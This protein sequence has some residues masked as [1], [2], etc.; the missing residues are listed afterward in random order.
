MAVYVR[1]RG[2][3]FE[4]RVKHR[5]LPRAFYATFEVEAEAWS[6]GQ[7]LDALLARGVVP[8][9]LATRDAPRGADPLLIEVIRGYTKAAPITES[10]DALLGTMLAELDGVR[11]SRV[12][13]AWC[14]EYVRQLKMRRNLAPSSI[15]KRVGVLARVVD[16]HLRRATLPGEQ[17]PS[18][19]LRLL[20]RG[21]S[22]YT[23]AEAQQL[24]AA[25]RGQA[26]K[27]DV[28]RDRRLAA[29]EEARIRAALAGQKRPDRERALA[30]DPALAMLFTLVLETGLRLREAYRLR[31]DQVDLARGILHVEGSKGH[32]GAIKPRTV[33]IKPALASALRE[34]LRGRVGLLFPF[35]SGSPEDLKKATA[36]LSARFA[37]LFEYAKVA[38]LTEHDLRHEATCR[39]VELRSPKGGWVFSDIEIC[40]IMGWR[41]PRMMLRYA[42]LRGEDLA[43]RLH[44][45]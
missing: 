17:A 38:D 12:T 40:R 44:G 3:R 43:A 10:D 13:F 15:R 22:T 4:L 21:Y 5:L 42:S 37:V 27:R 35:W 7:Q 23:R 36:R 45:R 28:E 11:L 16:W 25:G 29:E 26:A 32:R 24:E 20:P 31:V 8:A 2:A 30:A 34:Y 39:W 9:E 19:A 14:D 33:P 1:A 41:D 6:Y 18:N